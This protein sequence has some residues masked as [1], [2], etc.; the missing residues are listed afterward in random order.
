MPYR[1]NVELRVETKHRVGQAGKF[2]YSHSVSHG[3]RESCNSRSSNAVLNV[4]LNRTT[5]RIRPVKHDRGKL[6]RRGSAHNGRDR[7]WV[8]VVPRT[9]ILKVDHEGVYICEHR[10]GWRMQ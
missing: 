10:G 5:N 8:G 2:A 6:P 3:D 7:G 4:P 9:G 1:H